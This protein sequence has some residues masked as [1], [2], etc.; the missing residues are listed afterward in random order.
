M[1]RSAITGTPLRERT[2]IDT[3]VSASAGSS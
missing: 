2:T 1:A 3:G